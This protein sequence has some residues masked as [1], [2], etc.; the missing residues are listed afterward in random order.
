MHGN[1]VSSIV[2]HGHEWN[3][4]LPLPELYCRIGVVQVIARSDVRVAHDPVRLI[5]YL[6]GVMGR[7]PE[8]RVWN[9]SWNETASADPI[10]V[11]A[12]GH[13]LGVL[14]RKH[15]VLL[16]I[17]A[18]NV[19]QTQGNR[20]A[21]PADCEAALVVGGRQF[22]LTGSPTT[23]CPESLPGYGPEYLL[24]P[25]VTTYSPLRLLGG[26]VSRGTSFPTG[27]MSALAAHAFA[28]LRDPTPDFVRA[29]ILDRTELS[30][31]DP[32]LGWGT[33]RNECMPWHCAPGAVTF[34]FRAALGAGIQYYWEEIP[35]PRELMRN[36][37]LFGHVSITT[38][39]HPLCNPEGGPNYITT[40]VAASVQYPSIGGAYTRLVGSKELD[41]TAEL[42]ARSE[43]YKWQPFRRDCRDFTRRGGIGFGGPSF[44]VYARLYAREIAQFG[45]RVNAD[46]PEI[47]TVFVI[48]FSDGTA[49]PQLY[50][51]MAA[52]LGEF[53]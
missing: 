27:L 2:I 13:D 50:N 40:R 25:H 36:G 53:R 5:S 31:Y 42:T 6:D 37:K 26:R 8:T 29:L 12:L 7:H 41:N 49:G 46:I 17:S 10:L 39:H 1:Q 24:V 16:V 20:I 47:D 45:Y 23:H 15:D 43:E 30:G 38:V 9:L 18:G 21:P 28:N 34:A 48:T 35:I 33:P 22:D 44:R 19:S 11:S 51:S 32:H 14:A 4:N 52:S 3:N